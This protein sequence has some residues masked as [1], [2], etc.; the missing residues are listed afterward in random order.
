MERSGVNV[1]Y[2]KFLDAF[3]FEAIA[4]STV[5]KALTAATYMPAAAKVAGRAVIIVE[6]GDIRCR[7]DG[8]APTSTVGMPAYN[9]DVIV[10]EGGAN[11][12]NFKAIK[13]STSAAD[14][15]L[16]VTYERN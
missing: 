4:V 1:V 10:L 12:A 3:A 13:M 9:G 6:G 7:W 14:A 5:A 11:L 16:S 15:S 8:G 2:G